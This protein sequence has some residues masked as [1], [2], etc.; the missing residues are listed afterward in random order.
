M[1]KLFIYL[2]F[3]VGIYAPMMH[4]LTECGPIIGCLSS[5]SC[6]TNCPGCDC[7][8]LD[9]CHTS[10]CKT[11]LAKRSQ[12]SDTAR[13]MMGFKA[14]V[15]MM[16]DK[17]KTTTVMITPGFSRS[18][19]NEKL[20]SFFLPKPDSNCVIF[21]TN[22]QE[23]NVLRADDF[24]LVGTGTVCICPQLSNFFIDFG[25]YLDLKS[26]YDGLFFEIHAP[27]VHTWWDA[28][29][30]TC[31]A[32]STCTAGFP[33]NLMACSEA[34][35]PAG[36]TNL[37]RALRGDFTWPDV[38]NELCFGVICKDRISKTRLADVR[39]AL[40]YYAYRCD[41][42]GVGIKAVGAIPAGNVPEAHF[43]LDPV[44]GN[45]GNPELGAGLMAHANFYEC[46][47]GSYFAW[48]LDGYASHLFTSRTQRRL[49]DLTKNG[50]F[51]RYLLLKKFDNK[52]KLVELER[53]PNLFAQPIKVAVDVQGDVSTML[54]YVGSCFSCDIGYNFWGRS[55]EKCKE[56]GCCIPA[57]TYGIKGTIPFCQ[58]DGTA[59][60]QT[61]S[62]A[63]INTSSGT[64]GATDGTQPR[65]LECDD[66]NICS[67]LNP[68]VFTQ[69]VFANINYSTKG[70]GCDAFFGIGGKVEFTDNCHQTIQQWQ[71]WV[72]GAANF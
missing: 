67:A 54:S 72:S 31:D 18:F 11:Y 32:S 22:S 49:F 19:N 8:E 52:V 13:W 39:L 29:C 70:L 58:P 30:S 48:Y 35:T 50:C 12:G 65:F 46:E 20:A 38:K 1:K 33:A 23:A 15:A 64:E 51:S 43:L 5:T 9:C 14:F 45:G 7:C 57:N 25:A 44:V 37:K 17:E 42:W 55:Q 68:S 3:L 47:D 28:N 71:V 63:T 36:T 69:A 10:T 66:L 6:S 40:G 21:Q 59:N 60:I 26:C 53:G 61:A 4:A 27:V 24:G 62:T 2:F 56:F 16:N 41:R 34:P